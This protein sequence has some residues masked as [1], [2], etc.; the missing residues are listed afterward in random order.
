MRG[1]IDL[2]ALA[3]LSVLDP[4]AGG[5]AVIALNPALIDRWRL[6]AAA[7]IVSVVLLYVLP[8]LTGDLEGMP[9]PLTFVLWQSGLNVLAVVLI[10]RVG[11]GFGGSGR[12][13]DTLLLMGW[14][15]ALTVPILLAQ[16]LVLLVMPSLNALVLMAAVALSIWLLIGFICA[17]HGFKSRAMVLLGAIMVV[18]IA[19]FVLSILL[20]IFGL[21][22]AGVGNV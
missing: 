10:H 3:R 6:L 11:R 1:E 2:I 22:P 17:V 8:I 21:Q 14:L 12:F 15:Q 4:V 13:A 20:M 9:S 18:V 5:R 19:S 16:L 7:V